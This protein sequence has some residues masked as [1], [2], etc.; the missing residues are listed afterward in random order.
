MS[1][2]SRRIVWTETIEIC[3]TFESNFSNDSTVRLRLLR[4]E[5]WEE[6]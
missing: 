1:L 4:K 5:T 3:I 2:K 6:E